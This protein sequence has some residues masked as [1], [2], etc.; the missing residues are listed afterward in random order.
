MG[1]EHAIDGPYWDRPEVGVALE[2]VPDTTAKALMQ[3]LVVAVVG[4]VGAI[5]VL[6]SAIDVG[7]LAVLL[8]HALHLDVDHGWGGRGG[9]SGSWPRKRSSIDGRG[10]L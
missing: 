7:R 1:I 5:A 2:A 10:C 9:R 8:G 4:F 3:V 6:C